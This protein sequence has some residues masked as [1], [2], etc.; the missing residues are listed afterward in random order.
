[1]ALESKILPGVTASI[2]SVGALGAVAGGAIAAVGNS[3]AVAKGELSGPAAAL[4]VARETVG[5]G[6]SAAAGMVAVRAIGAG[7]IVGVVVF[8]AAA[9][10]ANAL[11]DS[12]ASR[13][14]TAPPPVETPD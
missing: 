5:G 10:I 12:W 4:G 14:K 11:W 9:G 6:L 7:G 13:P 8:L 1:M 2:L 3:V